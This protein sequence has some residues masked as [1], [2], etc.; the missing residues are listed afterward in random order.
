MVRY[1]Y[2]G[3]G[4]AVVELEGPALDAAT[5]AEFRRSMEPVLAAE[6]GTVVL[7]LARVSFIDSSGLG[8]LVGLLKRVPSQEALHL[9]GLTPAVAKIFKLT[10]MSEVFVIHERVP[11][12]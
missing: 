11:R 4:L 3:G 9:A 6:H 7:D 5:C 10:R 8:A 1:G 12:P 2:R